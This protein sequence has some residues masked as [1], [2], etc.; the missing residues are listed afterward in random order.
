MGT[1]A[2][3]DGDEI[4]TGAVPTKPEETVASVISSAKKPEVVPAT[5]KTQEANGQV[6]P[7]SNPQS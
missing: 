1:P 3:Y 7:P 5:E 2:T 4:A 6:V